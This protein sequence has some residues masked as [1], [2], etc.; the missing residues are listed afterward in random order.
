[1]ATRTINSPGVEIREK[2]LSLTAPSNVGTTV[3]IPG[4]ANQGPLDQVIKITTREEL[5][6]IY[7]KPT[8]SA[9]RYFYYTVNEALNSPANIYTTRLPYGA[10]A[11]VGFG[12]KYSALAYPVRFV[13]DTLGWVLSSN[14]ASLAAATLS[15]SSLAFTFPSGRTVSVAFSSIGAPPLPSLTASDVIVTYT[16]VTAPTQTIL[17]SLSTQ[18]YTAVVTSAPATSAADIFSVTTITATDARFTL[19]GGTSSVKTIPVFTRSPFTSNTTLRTV[20]TNLDPFSWTSDI[21]LSGYAGNMG[22]SYVLGEPT[23]LE[24][25]DTEYNSILDGS[26]LT[27][28]STGASRSTFTSLSALGQAGLVILNKGQTTIDEQFEGYY[29]GILDNSN[30]NPGTPYNGIRSIKTVNST[31]SSIV[32]NSYLTIPSST[33]EFN[34][35]S[36]YFT[37]PTDSVSLVLENL[38]GYDTG[39]REDDDL[40]NIG[41]F[42]LRKSVFANQATKLDYWLEDGITGSIDYF[43]TQLNPRGGPSIPY[44]ISDQDSKSRNVTVLVNDFVSG[45]LNPATSQS[46]RTNKRVRALGLNTTTSGEATTGLSDT[47]VPVLSSSIGYADSLF[48][49]G[50]YT[51]TAYNVKALGNLPQKIQRALDGVRNDDIYDI[52]LV[53]EAGLGTVNVAKAAFA[54]STGVDASGVNYDEFSNTPTLRSYI[55]SLRTSGDL[56]ITGERVRALYTDV[57]NVFESFCSPPYDGGGRGDC[58]FI[59]D[60]LRH[61]FISGENAKTLDDRVNKN[62]QRDIYWAI[63]HQFELTNSSYATSYANWCKIFDNYTGR[64]VWVPFSGFAASAIANSQAAT[65]PWIAPAGFTRGLVTTSSDLAVNP[66]QKQRD[67][68]YK[69]GFNPVAFFPA[70]GQVIYGQKTLLK[71]PSA[72]DRIN[73]RRLFLALERPVRKAAQFYVFEP[74]TVYT[75]TRLVNTLTPIFERAKATEGLYDYL[76]VCDERNNTPQVID[77]N[78]LIVDI[79]IKPVRAAEFILVNF[80][81]TRTDASFQEIVGA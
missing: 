31:V 49:L 38:A 33:L 74:N 57:F 75:R 13:T 24:I 22:G 53:A 77:N 25:S 47:I 2:D 32:G 3:F 43:R 7:G 40:L 5:D 78:E 81:A 45:R 63:R 46:G 17:A 72:F 60:P 29:V 71:K 70:Q 58:M 37:G 42:K 36:D 9:E 69:S 14:N 76:I 34:L 59:A 48:A 10:G 62:F 51:N 80:Y 23:H 55:D 8:N 26:G 35:S 67:E 61:I 65:Y 64:H 28:S 66:N 1:M 12:S 16:G 56:S 73:V 27:W 44:F 21:A 18:L 11:G 15:A 41:V 4:F 30:I 68:L 79:Y 6:L 20:T 50:A 39:T 54:E 19:Q 52:D